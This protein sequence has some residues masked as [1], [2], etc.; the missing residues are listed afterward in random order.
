MKV[1]QKSTIKLLVL[2]VLSGLF[3]LAGPLLAADIDY[4]TRPVTVHVG[5][6][7]GA[8]TS[9]GAQIVLEGLP[10]YYTKPQP[11]IINHKPGASGM[12]AADYFMKQPADGY[13]LMWIAADT[14]IAMAKEPQKLSFTVKD[15]AFIGHFDY[16]SFVVAVS[17][18]SL[19]ETFEDFIDYAKKHP[20]EMTCFNRWD[21]LRASL[22]F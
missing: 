1:A 16:N 2:L 18:K 21:R 5:M 12:V 6:A 14:W 11:F 10:R 9:I 19:F 8:A 17:N 4:P 7:P 22:R 15:F 20:N 13:N 3:F